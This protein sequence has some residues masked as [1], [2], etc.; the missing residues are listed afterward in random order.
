[1]PDEPIRV[2]GVVRGG[3]VHPE[4]SEPLPEGARV[5]ILVPVVRAAP[6]PPADPGEGGSAADQWEREE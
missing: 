5:E 2:P 1:M 6:T 3:V 4:G